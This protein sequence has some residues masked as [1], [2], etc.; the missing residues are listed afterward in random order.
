MKKL[1]TFIF[2]AF[3]SF[4]LVNAQT[5]I[6]FDVND[7]NG[8]WLGYMNVFEKDVNGGAF[9]FDSGWGVPDLIVA[10]DGGANT[11]AFSPNRVNDL[12]A[13]WNTGGFEGE[14]AMQA[15]Y[16][17]DRGDLNSTAFDFVANISSFTLV[18]TGLSQPYV[19]EMFIKVFDAGYANLLLNTRIPITA[20]GDYMV[21]YDGNTAGAARVQYGFTMTGVNINP[22][23]AFDAHAHQITIGVQANVVITPQVLSLDD[24]ELNAFK[25]YPNP[26]NG[27]WNVSSTS[28]IKT[29]E[30][31]DVL[32]Q[33]VSAQIPNALEATI[34]GGQF[35]SGLY[36]A[37]IEGDNGTKTVRLVRQ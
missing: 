12:N 9:V 28:S 6:N 2:L 32:G 4:T 26:S 23:A 20:A 1:Y 11:A 16:Y 14:K 33:R 36:F 34:D 24:Q 27:N 35:Q 18:S 31:F 30:V 15:D 10:E 13:F 21:S 17:I 19:V 37:K 7:A 5:T 22:T 8:P 25:V 29:I 3:C